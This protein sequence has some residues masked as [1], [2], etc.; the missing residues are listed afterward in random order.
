MGAKWKDE[1]DRKAEVPRTTALGPP[2][3]SKTAPARGLGASTTF[4][5]V[6]FLGALVM[7]A[8]SGNG[9]WR[10]RSQNATSV[11]AVPQVTLFT[12]PGCTLCD[13]AVAQLKETSQPF[14]LS[15]VNIEA[16]GNEAWKSRYWCDIPVFHINGAFWAKHRLEAEDVEASLLA[17]AEGTFTQRDGEPDSRKVECGEDGDCNCATPRAL[18]FDL[19][20]ARAGGSRRNERIAALKMFQA[21][22]WVK[23]MDLLPDHPG[24]GFWATPCF[25]D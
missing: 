1:L 18:P 21:G 20:T 4:R 8:K 10:R 3:L 15:T 5:H 12:K 16:P 7:A 6:S 19:Q 11:A 24:K 23:T 14:E 9:T 17:A 22:S 2:R 25:A 13:K